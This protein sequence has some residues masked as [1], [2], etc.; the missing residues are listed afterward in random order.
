MPASLAM[1][2]SS[3]APAEL[4]QSSVQRTASQRRIISRSPSSQTESSAAPSNS[5]AREPRRPPPPAVPS[6]QQLDVPEGTV[7]RRR[8]ESPL[9]VPPRNR[10][11]ADV[12]QCLRRLGLV[13]RTQS[14]PTQ[15]SDFE[16]KMQE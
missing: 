11:E 10:R 6:D 9:H 16:P 14:N 15:I 2:T 3:R 4:C 12:D 8:Q 5:T 1:R 13:E 7:E